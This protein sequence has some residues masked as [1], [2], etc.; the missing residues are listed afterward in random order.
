MASS[1]R[2]PHIASSSQPPPPA[3]GPPTPISLLIRFSIS[4]PDLALSIPFANTTSVRNLKSQI[5]ARLPPEQSRR[6]L[7]LIHS[8]K[9]LSDGSTLKQLRHSRP[10]PPP[11]RA[12][13]GKGKGKAKAV[14]EDE[15]E[16]EQRRAVYVHCSVGEELSDE[17]LLKEATDKEVPP[18][19]I[20]W[21][22]S[23]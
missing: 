5:R 23:S 3:S 15:S 16:G 22:A 6:R 4:L 20:P 12:D 2:Q 9:V 8:G 14:D 13:S 11:P 1:S 18:L 10:L 7:R 17:E 19:R 21:D